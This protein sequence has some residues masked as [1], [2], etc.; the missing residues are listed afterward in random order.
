MIY[1]NTIG[2]RYK[3]HKIPIGCRKEKFACE[4]ESSREE[5]QTK[6]KTFSGVFV[7]TVGFPNS[8]LFYLWWILT[9][10]NAVYML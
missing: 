3:Q 8:S 4:R 5:Q 1:S 6:K 9:L 7:K 2:K 10:I